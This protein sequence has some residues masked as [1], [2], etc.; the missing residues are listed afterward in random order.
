[1][2]RMNWVDGK[3]GGISGLVAGALGCTASYIE[4]LSFPDLAWLWDLGVA[5]PLAK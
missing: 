1:M 3:N 5:H 2:A 4:G